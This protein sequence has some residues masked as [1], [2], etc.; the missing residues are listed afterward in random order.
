MDRR[1]LV[2]IFL[3]LGSAIGFTIGLIVADPGLA[4]VYGAGGAGVGI[5]LGAIVASL[6][7]GAA[8]GQRR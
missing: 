7:S 5:V 4:A 3:I 2:A 8:Q 1:Y 6:S